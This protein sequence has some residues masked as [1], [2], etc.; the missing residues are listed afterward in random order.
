MS[1]LFDKRSI[2]ASD[3][4]PSRPRA[5]WGRPSRKRAHLAHSAAWACVGLRAGLVST[6]PIDVYFKS[7][8]GAKQ[9]QQTPLVLV[10]P[11]G[12]R[13]DI[14]EWMYSTQ[15]DLDT[16]GN[17]FGLITST[18]YG[19]PSR[20]DLVPTE[21]VTVRSE[22]GKILYWIDGTKYEAEQVWH[23]RQYTSS[24]LAVGLSP[25]G[26]AAMT[27]HQ[28]HTAQEFAAALFGG[29]VLPAGL[30][31]HTDKI[32]DPKDA[33]QVKARYR[34]AIEN[35][36]IFVVGKDWEFKPANAIK[37]QSEFIATMGFADLEM[38]RFFGVPAD[39]VDVTAEGSHITYANITQRNLQFLIMNLGP[40]IIRRETALTRL[41]APPQFVK[42][43]TAALLRMDP[44]AVAQTLGQQVRDRIMTPTEAREKLDL[45]PL[46][47]E[48]LGEFKELFPASF[49]NDSSG[50]PGAVTDAVTARAVAEL[51]QKIYLGVGKVLTA[52]EARE[53]A[54]RAG[55]GLTGTF[56]PQGV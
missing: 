42:L 48:Q 2:T 22:K 16:V 45:P 3:L 47:E 32:V 14:V 5:S 21:A 23:E 27:L 28:Q 1:I 31:Q 34:L 9:H 44:Q 46:T 10:E 19:I 40:A 15:A 50:Q 53:I 37:A 54:N 6:M 25:V 51:I 4:I 20:I 26:Y 18:D 11:G 52:D 43:N 13:V 17:A 41:V 30:L 7:A 8:T 36:D 39:L 33:E 55:A 12:N 56:T 24:G 29:N 35:N 38:C 49:T